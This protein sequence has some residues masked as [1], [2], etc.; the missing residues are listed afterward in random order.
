MCMYVCVLGGYI[1]DVKEEV[2][3]NENRRKEDIFKQMQ[4]KHHRCSYMRIYMY[5]YPYFSLQGQRRTHISLTCSHDP[6]CPDLRNRGMRHGCAGDDKKGLFQLLSASSQRMKPPNLQDLF[7]EEREID[8]N[9]ERNRE[10]VRRFNRERAQKLERVHICVWM[11]KST[12]IMVS[13][14]GQQ[15]HTTT[16]YKNIHFSPDPPALAIIG[17]AYSLVHFTPP[18][19]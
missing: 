9:W 19:Q 4:K 16:S 11:R 18:V 7:W 2:D 5:I 6:C 14:L 8:R 15:V 13:R 17:M 12:Y 1:Y 10:Y 3:H